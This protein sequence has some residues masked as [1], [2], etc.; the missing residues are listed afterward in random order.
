M[1][2]MYCA[3]TLL[4]IHY[5]FQALGQPIIKKLISPRWME[6]LESYLSGSHT[7]LCLMSLKVLNAISNFA[8]GKDQK[9]LMEGLSWNIKA[10]SSYG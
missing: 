9:P 4:T 2:I 5:D 3:V 1:S 7:E 6:K 8:N 10:C